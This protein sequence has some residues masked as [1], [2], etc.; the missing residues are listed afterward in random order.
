MAASLWERAVS[1]EG[2]GRT[3]ISSTGSPGVASGGSRSPGTKECVW[4]LLLNLLP[5]DLQR[6]APRL[7]PCRLMSKYICCSLVPL[8]NIWLGELGYNRGFAI[9]STW[10]STM[11]QEVFTLLLLPLGIE[12]STVVSH[13]LWQRWLAGHQNFLSS[14]I[15]HSP[16]WKAATWPAM[17]S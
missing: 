14:L 11:T 5:W 12:G 9:T 15:L 1:I 2:G 13:S 4:S 3:H 6:L 7:P 8:G 17:C 10:G 16:G